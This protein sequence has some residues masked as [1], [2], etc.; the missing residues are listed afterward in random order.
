MKTGLCS[1]I[2]A[3][4]Q[5]TAQES[6]PKEYSLVPNRTSGALYHRVSISCVNVFIGNEKALARP[7]SAIFTS[8]SF[9]TRIF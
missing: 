6:T 9:E 4:I 7:K 1:Y 8:S 2:S 5:P 3:N